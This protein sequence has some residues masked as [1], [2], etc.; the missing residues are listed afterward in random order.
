M[1]TGSRPP[2]K[3]RK[4]MRAA[5][6][7]GQLNR[8]APALFASFIQALTFKGRAI[9]RKTFE[10]RL[11]H[12]KSVIEELENSGGDTRR[13]VSEI[14]ELIK[15]S[16]AEYEKSGLQD[17]RPNYYATQIEHLLSRITDQAV[18]SEEL[19][20]L[21]IDPMTAKGA[22]SKMFPAEVWN[23]SYSAWLEYF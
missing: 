5:V 6:S 10:Y 2:K 19:A 8:P 11:G 12:W 17:L 20:A 23:A 7:R 4:R 22:P 9:S 1:V 16:T 3:A 13:A 15:R 18:V 14:G 21:K